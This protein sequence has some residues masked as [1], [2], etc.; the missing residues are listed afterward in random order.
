MKSETRS[1]AK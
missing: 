1:D